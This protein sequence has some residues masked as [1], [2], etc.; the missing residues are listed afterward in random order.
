MYSFVFFSTTTQYLI[1][2][3]GTS[4]CI[5]I[6]STEQ[7]F[8]NNVTIHYI[9]IVSRRYN[10]GIR[11]ALFTFNIYTTISCRPNLTIDPPQ[12]L[13]QT[14]SWNPIVFNRPDPDGSSKKILLYIMCYI[15]C[16]YN[17]FYKTNTI[18]ILDNFVYVVNTH[19]TPSPN[20]AG[21]MYQ[22]AVC[23]H[24]YIFTYY[25]SSRIWLLI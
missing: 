4:Q 5:T 22:F 24:L 2:Y 8:L 19:C 3:Y 6:T 21:H 14:V 11:Y 13:T 23:I 25:P 7:L 17:S 9:R 18:I 15:R 20:S 16:R 12:P 1:T 10:I